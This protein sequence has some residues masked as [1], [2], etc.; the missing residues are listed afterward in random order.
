MLAYLLALAVTV[1]V[2][3]PVYAL[4]LQ[5]E[6]TLDARRGAAAGV[7]VNLVSHPLAFLVA[8]PLIAPKFGFLPAL[9]VV[10]AGVWTLEGLLLW[11]WRRCDPERLGLAA[12]VA[13]LLSL[14]VGLALVA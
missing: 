12:L 2:E 7:I 14:S 1:V 11:A 10:E 3:T 5:R 4:M 6:L 13:N 9:I 8:M